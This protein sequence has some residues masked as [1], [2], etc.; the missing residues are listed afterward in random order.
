MDLMLNKVLGTQKDTKMSGFAVLQDANVDYLDDLLLDNGL[1]KIVDA[2]CLRSIHHEHLMIWCNK[3]G[4]YT[5]PTTE[6]IDW[7]KN[8][9]GNRSAIEICA[10]YGSIGR[11]LKIPITDSHMQTKPEV[12]A[13]Y[14]LL[15]QNPIRPP[16][17]VHKLEAN[18]AIDKFKPQVVIG[19][20]VTQKYQSG[21][22]GSPTS[23]KIN[24]S[25]YGVDEQSMLKKI[26]TYINIGND[27]SHGDKRIKKYRHE[28]H[29]FDWLFTRSQSPLLNHICVWN[30]KN[31]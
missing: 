24:S 4:S 29:R 6:L 16:N 20:F 12:I 1:P 2:D 3:F 11:A 5:I 7:L 10:G 18:D 23:P 30:M 19:C 9:I 17:D 13:Y 15:G 28:L 21:D 27:L 8:Q 26:K 14:R 25:V 31:E 22:E